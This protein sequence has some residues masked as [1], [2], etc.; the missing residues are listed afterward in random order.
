MVRQGRARDIGAR[1]AQANKKAHAHA[2]AQQQGPGLPTFISKGIE[3]L[4]PPPWSYELLLDFMGVPHG[5]AADPRCGECVKD[6]G[7]KND[8]L[9]FDIQ[10]WRGI[11]LPKCAPV[12]AGAQK[13]TEILKDA[14]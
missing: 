5:A 9:E 14:D 6:S 3:S 2:T 1:R 7:K 13:G 4:G 11:T 8:G 12:R 10:I